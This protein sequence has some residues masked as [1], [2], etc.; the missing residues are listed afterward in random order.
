MSGSDKSLDAIQMIDD[1]LA[2]VRAENL[3]L[4]NLLTRWVTFTED[5][6]GMEKT[7]IMAD[8]RAA[9]S[10]QGRAE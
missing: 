6:P 10:S 7:M 4:R 1:R 3:R 9:L 8:T 2:A 5:D